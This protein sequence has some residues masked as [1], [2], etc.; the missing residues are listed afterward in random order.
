MRPASRYGLALT[1][2]DGV[3]QGSQPVSHI[4]GGRL[5]RQQMIAQRPQDHRQVAEQATLAR[6]PY[7][8]S[9]KAPALA[10][11]GECGLGRTGVLVFE[12]A[13][14]S[15]LTSSLQSLTP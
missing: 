9:V 7:H 15:S 2:L 6:E 13:P 11:S 12:A 5:T 8:V 3:N 10:H 14:S 1:P 4:Q